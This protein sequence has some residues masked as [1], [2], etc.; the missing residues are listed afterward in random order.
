VKTK[1]KKQNKQKPQTKPKQNIPS[2]NAIQFQ[3]DLQ[4]AVLVQSLPHQR[5]REKK[6]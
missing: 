2:S 4:H 3:L 5:K 6:K 1:N